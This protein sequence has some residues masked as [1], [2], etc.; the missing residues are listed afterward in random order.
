VIEESQRNFRSS[1]FLGGSLGSRE[2][3]HLSIHHKRIGIL[4]EQEAR[5]LPVIVDLKGYLRVRVVGVLAKF[6]YQPASKISKRKFH[7]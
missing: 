4:Y 5:F 6:Y 1:R 7:L 3:A 2:I